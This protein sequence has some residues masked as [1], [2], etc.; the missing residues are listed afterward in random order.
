MDFKEFSNCDFAVTQVTPVYQYYKTDEEYIMYDR[1]N[2]GLF[3]TSNCS[4]EYYGENGEYLR[5]GRN[6]IVLVPENSS[7]KVV[8]RE[9][10]G[11]V[12]DNKLSDYIINFKLISGKFSEEFPCVIADKVTPSTRL[13]IEDIFSAESAKKRLR[14]NASFY[15]LLSNLLCKVEANDE[16]IQPAVDYLNSNPKFNSLSVNSL[17]RMCNM[18]PT[19]FRRHFETAFG[20][21][22]SQYIKDNYKEMAK[23]YLVT[24]Q[25]SVKETS[26]ILGFNDVSYFSRFFKENMGVSAS[27]IK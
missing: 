16:L 9:S 7:Y 12:E 18:H 15:A 21:S 27:H 8:F 20:I 1:I 4:V 17:A 19:T 13:I 22:P 11:S 6:N 26:D 5:V 14:L 24:E 2:N 25:R 10:D 23:Y 3:F